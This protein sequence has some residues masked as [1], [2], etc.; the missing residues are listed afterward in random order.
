MSV[1]RRLILAGR[2]VALVRPLALV[3][4][5]FGFLAAATAW[6]AL[7]ALEAPAGVR[8][9]VCGWLVC[10]HVLAAWVGSACTVS[11]AVSQRATE[12]A[13]LQPANYTT[14]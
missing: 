2:Y 10:L 4:V 5:V 12:L 3:A 1:G 8:W 7:V 13:R 11:R 14:T 9:A 6:G